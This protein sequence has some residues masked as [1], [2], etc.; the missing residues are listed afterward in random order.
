MNSTMFQRNLDSYLPSQEYLD[1][2]YNL[3]DK[4]IDLMLFSK[5]TRKMLE[6]SAYCYL[7]NI[8]KEKEVKFY[9]PLSFMF[10]G[11]N[12]A[13]MQ[14]S[15]TF[16]SCYKEVYCYKSAELIINEFTSRLRKIIADTEE[17][18]FFSKYLLASKEKTKYK[19]HRPFTMIKI[20]RLNDNK[21]INVDCYNGSPNVHGIILDTKRIPIHFNEA[22][23]SNYLLENKLGSAILVQNPIIEIQN[24]QLASLEKSKGKF[25]YIL[26]IYK[27]WRECSDQTKTVNKAEVAEP[28]HYSAPN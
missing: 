11:I 2:T 28:N 22:N 8:K 24:N 5:E 6:N 3:F 1:D 20:S 12:H 16:L 15:E 23:T 19:Y 17:T 13:E 4:V 21:T 10:N 25:V 9:T 7:K 14:L 26:Y 18:W 27:T